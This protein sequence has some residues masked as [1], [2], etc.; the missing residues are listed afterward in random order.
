MTSIVV[1]AVL[2]VSILCLS[3]FKDY[4]SS[5]SDKW[6]RWAWV[7]LAL[8]ILNLGN[9]VFV[10]IVESRAQR[11][12]ERANILESQRRDA[13]VSKLEDVSYQIRILGE[14]SQPVRR[15]PAKELLST[16]EGVK[17]KPVPS[18][19][20]VFT[21]EPDWF[22]VVFANS[23]PLNPEGQLRGDGRPD[24]AVDPQNGYPAAV[25]SYS[26]GLG[27]DLALSAWTYREET[28]PTSFEALTGP[29]T[30]TAWGPTELISERLQHELDPRIHIDEAGTVF[31]VWWE[32]GAQEGVYLTA[33]QAGAQWREPRRVVP[34]GRRPS[35]LA[36]HGTLLVACELESSAQ[37]QEVVV[38]SS[39]AQFVIGGTNRTEPLQPA[40]HSWED[41]LWI[42]WIHS[43]HEIAY[44]SFVDGSWE[45]P[46]VIPWR[47]RSFIGMEEGRMMIRA[48]ILAP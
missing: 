35:V 21:A 11:A 23:E 25:W 3:F 40:L 42:D 30:Y 8:L 16:I 4:L 26:T 12:A 39:V 48:T 20:Y 45:K 24:V 14:S 36:W 22:P 34:S 47:N 7:A 31:V 5:E 19:V 37:G 9:V 1:L 43:D 2:S 44:A 33:R 17:K 41:N 29:V 6:K 15:I 46:S 27:L 18:D 13:I 32:E 38:R 28:T 10:A